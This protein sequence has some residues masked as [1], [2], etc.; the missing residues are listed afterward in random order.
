[1]R[2]RHAI[3]LLVALAASAALAAP[4]EVPAE[5][6][7]APGQ[8]VRVVVKGADVGYKAA[9]TD[10]EAFFEELAPRDGQRRFMFYA[11]TP[12]TYVVVFWSKGETDGVFT[13]VTVG[14]APPPQPPGPGPQPTPG[15]TPPP[16]PVT[17]FHVVVIYESGDTLTANQRAVVYGKAVEDYLNAACTG[18]A[19]GWRRRDKD[20]PGELDPTMAALWAAVQ[21][22]VT[23]TPCVAVEVNGKVDLIPLEPTPAAMIAKLKIYRGQ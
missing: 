13:R 9:F 7:A 4:P 16:G 6:K 3:P 8:P 21:P 18:G 10:A 14:S 11:Q 1:M 12:G 5:V 15:P 23:V 22:K 20:S 19:A 2:I 17:S